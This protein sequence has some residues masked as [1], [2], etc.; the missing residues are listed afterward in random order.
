LLNLINTNLKMKKTITAIF[1]CIG[2]FIMLAQPFF[3]KTMLYS[4]EMI[5]ETT[6][7]Q[8]GKALYVIAKSY[9]DG[10]YLIKLDIQGNLLWHRTIQL[11][12]YNSFDDC[13][14]SLL[15]TNDDAV[16]F[17]IK[18]LDKNQNQSLRIVKFDENGNLLWHK[19]VLKTAKNIWAN[20]VQ[21]YANQQQ[22]LYVIASIKYKESFL[23][24][25]LDKDGNELIARKINIGGD[26]FEGAI[27]DP[28][29]D[30][31]IVYDQHVSIYNNQLE[32]TARYFLPMF[33]RNA[34]YLNGRLYFIGQQSGPPYRA[35]LICCDATDLKK[36]YWMQSANKF[37]F[38]KGYFAHDGKN[39]YISYDHL[40]FK[41]TTPF[42]PN[43]IIYKIA[44]NGAKIWSKQLDKCN[45]ENGVKMSIHNSK[46][47]LAHS[48]IQ[49]IDTSGNTDCSVL[50][51]TDS[52]FKPITTKQIIQ[53][54]TFSNAENYLLPPQNK[55]ITIN[56]TD[57]VLKDICF[58]KDSPQGLEIKRIY[59]L[60]DT[61]SL[62]PSYNGYYRYFFGE[63]T[64]SKEPLFPPD[65][66]YVFDK[67]RQDTLLMTFIY[68]K[69][70]EKQIKYP[71]EVAPKPSYEPVKDTI[72]CGNGVNV[73]LDNNFQYLWA[74]GDR[75]A[76]KQLKANTTYN[77]TITDK[78]GCTNERNIKV[79]PLQV[80][81]IQTDTLI[82]EYLPFTFD[83][84]QFENTSV[85]NQV[86]EQ[87]FTSSEHKNFTLKATI[88]GCPI[89]KK[90]FVERQ[91]CPAQIYVPT[92]FS[93]NGDGINDY[94]EVFSND[95]EIMN[96]S[97]YNR[98]GDKIFTLTQATEPWNGQF[99]DMPAPEGV[100]TY[101]L[102]YKNKRNQQ[103][104]DLAGDIL[105]LRGGE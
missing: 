15:C 62:Y 67:P 102:R 44:E 27:F 82:C 71:F 9:W 78:N 14:T 79:K 57:V 20:R 94:F 54:S 1:F 99:K 46:L 36:V 90:L 12:Q 92:T 30:K 97:I 26:F 104:E 81:D 37:D 7:T 11:E 17:G 70:C 13:S 91:P 84:S 22:E 6:Y 56:T 39:I 60:G 66:Q 72:D 61:I 43:G 68:G 2:H 64:K 65:L 19:T 35:Q 85:D 100:Y 31:I 52:Y 28:I 8:S 16:I 55:D 105:L 76:T 10:T 5:F 24:L 18:S 48:S 4:F 74:D 96:Y 69:S 53:F 88:K 59:C 95:I 41:T 80:P 63:F 83:L 42:P 3:N 21:I 93:P 38:N 47:L 89:S 101:H 32:L 75:K 87:S 40:N 86:V 49:Q 51:V 23:L 34:M 33:T 29:Q 25:K 45:A 77:L 58:E 50:D 103:Q 98:W 73:S